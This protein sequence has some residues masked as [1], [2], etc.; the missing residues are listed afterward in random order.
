MGW[1]KESIAIVKAL[2]RLLV[3]TLKSSLLT[4]ASKLWL[5]TAYRTF[6]GSTI[7]NY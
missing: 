2:D 7:L 3:A 4:Q 1:W 6:C 5:P